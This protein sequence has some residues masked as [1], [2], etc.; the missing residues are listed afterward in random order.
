METWMA[1]PEGHLCLKCVP[2]K[3]GKSST[4]NY[5]C[6]GNCLHI[7][8]QE[9]LHQL[10]V[11]LMP[12][13]SLRRPRTK[14]RHEWH[15]KKAIYVWNVCLPRRANHQLKI[16]NAKAIVFTFLLQEV[17]PPLRIWL[18]PI[19][20]LRRPR[21][22]RRHEWFTQRVNLHLKCVPTKEGKSST[23]NYK[24]Q[25]HCLHIFVARSTDPS[26]DMINA[27]FQFA[28]T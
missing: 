16:T 8:I 14:W 25:G 28:Q 21:T 15:N 18:M 11:W 19:F 23:E 26:K 5:K 17:L 24:C 7:L 2:T 13:F 4:K 6:Q 27:H 1:Q 12:V 9:I 20:S 22:K 10:R 3:E